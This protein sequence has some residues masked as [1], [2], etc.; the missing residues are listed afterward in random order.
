MVEVVPAGAI[1]DS[2]SSPNVKA[3]AGDDAPG[4]AG[5]ISSTINFSM[6]MCGVGL[7]IMPWA[8][9]QVGIVPAIILVI[10]CGILTDY[11]FQLM[12]KITE[13]SRM[14]SYEDSARFYMGK[15]GF[16]IVSALV[17]F[18]L[19]LG[20]LGCTSPFA[21]LMAESGLECGKLVRP[22]GVL[23]QWAGCGE[24]GCPWL[25]QSVIGVVGFFIL[26]PSFGLKRLNALI[27]PSTVATIALII[28]VLGLF[29]LYPV[30]I[31]NEE[32][33]DRNT[34]GKC[35]TSPDMCTKYG[36]ANATC[37][38][39]FDK[40]KCSEG[41][42]GDACA[43]PY[44]AFHSTF[45]VGI[46]PFG[47]YAEVT[48]ATTTTT[49]AGTET[50]VEEEAPYFNWYGY[51]DAI[52]VIL[53]AYYATFQIF[54]LQS[55]LK[56]PEEA[57]KVV[58]TTIIGCCIPVYI[59]F[60]FV[61][62]ALFGKEASDAFIY[63]N[64]PNMAG[65][66]ACFAI[67]IAML[68]K[69][70]LYFSAVRNLII[71]ACK[72]PEN[73]LTRFLVSMFVALFHFVVG[74]F[75]SIKNTIILTGM[76]SGSIL[77]FVVP[78][79][80]VVQYIRYYGLDFHKSPA[81]LKHSNP[82]GEKC[83]EEGNKSEESIDD[84][85]SPIDIMDVLFFKGD[86]WRLPTESKLMLVSGWSLVVIGTVAGIFACAGFMKQVSFFTSCP[87]PEEA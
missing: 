13:K 49:I 75:I 31:S 38:A 53:L 37:M 52:G 11:T 40:C 7:M 2:P 56:R 10:L 83:A 50:E 22:E 18:D 26:V 63:K 85:N 28:C 19:N 82:N 68:C 42:F 32:W 5:F 4:H 47:P 78:G 15:Y 30:M 34:V 16:I 69:A 61:G 35:V 45:E 43:E 59:L 25:T 54:V 1:Q 62:Y 76:L 67:G 72:L 51:A 39:E 74:P 86:F 66:L 80:L 29:V 79:L 3:K 17:F 58:H 27:Y 55:E 48:T 64:V 12:I 9:A 71:G 24:G 77:G 23:R 36:D 20:A 65:K 14:T 84:K 41:F 57:P 21:V 60:G 44:E 81:D 6:T 46:D 33:T 87:A 73:F 70:P 8:F